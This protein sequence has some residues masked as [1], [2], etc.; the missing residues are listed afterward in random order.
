MTRFF[1]GEE[2]NYTWTWKTVLVAGRVLVGAGRK[3]DQVFFFLGLPGFRFGQRSF[4]QRRRI[5]LS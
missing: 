1:S 3:Q 5:G 4:I 2:N